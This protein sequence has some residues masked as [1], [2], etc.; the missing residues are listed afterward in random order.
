MARPSLQASQQSIQVA[1]QTLIS[2][3][4][5]Q[6]DL[7]AQ[8]G[9]SRHPVLRFFTG[10]PVEQETFISICSKLE[11]DWREMAGIPQAQDI[12]EKEAEC[13]RKDCLDITVLVQ[14][15]RSRIKPS[16]QERCG[17][18]R[19]LDMSQ[20]I[21]LSDIYTNVNILEKITGRRR[22]KLSD[23][24]KEYKLEELEEFERFGLGR[25]IEERIPGL[26][27]VE[28]YKKLIVLGKP[29]AGKT[30]FLKY[31]AIQCN[32]GHFKAE[33][34]PI[35]ITLKNFAEALDKPS[36]LEYISH[37]FFE[38]GVTSEQIHE[39]LNNGRALLLLDGLDEV[40]EEH[41][42][43]ILQEIRDFSETFYNN[44]FIMTCRIAAWEYTFDKFTEVEVSD[45]D[46]EQIQNFAQNWFRNKIV[47]SEAFI[48]RLKTNN[49]IQQLAVNPLLLTLLCLVF[50]ES[51]DLPANRSDLYKEGLDVF[52]KK[53]DA[54]RGIQRDEVYKN[55]SVRRKEDLLSQLALATF[56]ENKYFFSQREAEEYITI[57]IRDLPNT[58][59]DP[60]ALQLDS[61]AILRSIEA[62]Q[63]LLVER[64]KGV[65]SFSHLTFHEYFTAR[66]IVLR[67]H[68]LEE[69]LEE[70]VK[71]IND[72]R[73][74]EVFLL[75][76]EMLQPNPSML[77]NKMKQK[78]DHSLAD[79]EKLQKFLMSVE[80]RASSIKTKCA[81]SIKE[82]ALRAFCFDIDFDI[83]ENRSLCLL[84]DSLDSSEAKDHVANFLISASFFNRVLEKTDF[85][86]ALNIAQKHDDEQ[87]SSK[88]I[89]EAPSAN[90]VMYIA[91]EIALKSEN[92]KTEL[93]EPLETLYNKYLNKITY[94]EFDEEN[95]EHLKHLAD[96]ARSKAKENRH[97][98]EGKWQ[99][100]SNEKDLLK[101]YY[102]A[103]KLLIECLNSDCPISPDVR[104]KILNTLLLPISK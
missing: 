102:N 72:K 34:V 2:K 90:H 9:I 13:V 103:N 21:G 93:R 95:L 49:R 3:G 71:Y 58:N 12:V 5:K 18:M 10:K 66:E 80:H 24:H 75:A 61:E 23:L 84:L 7:V 55:L 85:T 33:F 28:K 83:D 43:R 32:G 79:R 88:K 22:K 65:Y 51:G 8:L 50:E 52:L 62:Q 6:K 46:D 64:A 87:K 4:L 98:K 36:L 27:A 100:N 81:I 74:R 57:Y 76:T 77:L 86:E 70:L 96:E 15:V 101:Q 45:F 82:S 91:I 69:A 25:V 54:K 37:Q 89:K 47:K 35:F 40:R 29:G 38:C 42:N 16:I 92:I 73:W 11:L 97:L 63:G 104:S 59:T 67:R 20:P 48:K 44:Y 94:E 1:K 17:T 19:V 53:W 39:L 26:K 78:I 41:H 68:P 31:I 99:F 14:E 30:T 60:K 56:K